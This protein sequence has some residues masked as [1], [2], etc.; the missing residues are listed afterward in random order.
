[1]GVK[2]RSTQKPHRARTPEAAPAGVA[3]RQGAL[4]LLESVLVQGQSLEGALPRALRD[5]DVPADR[6]LAR[7]IAAQVLRW[8][9]ELDA[10]ID[11]AT[12]Q[13]LSADARARTVLRIALVQALTMD[14][15]H[16]AVIATAL[17]LVSGGPR[18][19]VHGVLGHLLRS[20][21]KLPDTPHLPEAF[22][23]LLRSNWGEP[24][25]EAARAALV[26]QPPMDLQLRLGASP[27]PQLEGISLAPQHFRTASGGRIEQWPGFAEGQWWV[28]DLAASLPARWLAPAKGELVADLC[29][30]PGGKTLQLADMG[31]EVLAV[32]IAQRRL[33]RLKENLTRTGLTAEIITHDATTWQPG[34]PLSHILLDAPCSATG[35]FRRHPEILHLAPTRELERLT[36]L[37]AKLLDHAFSLLPVGGRLVYCTCSL[38]KAEGE[39]QIAA[40]LARTPAAQCLAPP[41]DLLPKGLAPTPQGYI[42]TLPGDLAEVGGID[43]FFIAC[44]TRRA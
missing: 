4:Y 44:L 21:A 19:L 8:S 30:A 37:Q 20:S 18:R 10:L 26:G 31:A 27:P 32:D 33:A 17:P 14:T 11:S 35:I 15:P 5:V 9:V 28:Q 36:A 38:A 24:W 40:F 23:E 13:P 22:A 39:D 29:A 3:A 16:H 7:A 42:R 1:M 6:A 34:R 43:S 41:Q 12:R 2:P 25:V